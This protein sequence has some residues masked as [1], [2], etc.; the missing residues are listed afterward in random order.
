MQVITVMM[1]MI[2]V[3]MV[4]LIQ[5]RRAYFDYFHHVHLISSRL[6]IGVWAPRKIENSLFFEGGNANF[7]HPL[8]LF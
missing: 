1:I 3:A 6:I 2:I 5:L 8:L 4:V 7:N